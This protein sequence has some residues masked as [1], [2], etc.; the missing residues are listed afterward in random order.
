MMKKFLTLFVALMT[1]TFTFAVY[2]TEPK[3]IYFNAGA[4]S[5]WTSDNAVQRAVLDGNT[6]S[7]IIGVLDYGSVYA[8]TIPAGYHNTIWF[9]RAPSATAPGPYNKTDYIDIAPTYNYVSSFSQNSSTV[10]WE[11]YMHPAITL[12]GDFNNWGDGDRI[13]FNGSKTITFVKTL[14]ADSYEFK[15]VK[16]ENEWRSSGAT[17]AR[18]N[19]GAVYDFSG[20]NSNNTTLIADITGD[21][22]FTYTYAT[23][24]LTVTFPDLPAQSVVFDDLDATILKG[25]EV[26]FAATASGITN[27]QYT[28]YVKPAGGSYG[29]AVSSYTFDTNGE[30]VVKVEAIGDGMSEPVIKEQTVTVYSTYTFTAGTRIYVDFSA[31]TEGAKG[32]NYPS[33]NTNSELDY[34]VNGAGTTKIVLISQNVTWSTLDDFIKTEKNGWAGLKFTAPGEGQNVIIVAADGASYTWGTH[35]TAHVKFFAPRTEL[36]QWSNVYVYAWDGAGDLSSDWPGDAVTTKEGEWYVY[37]MPVGAN[38]IFS[39]NNGMQTN[40]IE[41]IQ[42][43]VCYVPTAINEKVTVAEQCT[44]DYYISGTK[45]L[46]GLGSDW[47][48][49]DANL[50]LDANNQIKFENLAAGTYEFKIT[51]GTWAWS[52]GGGDH[53]DGECATIATTNGIG[54]VEFTIASVQDVTITYHPETERICLGAVTVQTPGNVTLNDINIKVG[55]AKQIKYTKNNTETYGA[56][57][58]ILSGEE[59]IQIYNGFVLG[60]KAGT[61]TVR[62]TIAETAN[63]TAASNEFTVTVSASSEP[64]V[65]PIAPVGGKFLINA[66]G[67]TA[68]FARGNLQYQQ[69]TNTWR[70]APNQYEWK[71]MSNIQM[72]NAEYEGWVDLFCWSLGAENNYGATSNYQKATYFNKEFVDWGT[73]FGDEWSTLS[74]DEL[75]YILNSRPGANNKWGVAMIGDTLGMMLLPD[76]WEAPAGITYV[77]GTNSLPTT[78]L[79]RDEDCIQDLDPDEIEDLGYQ[80]RLKKENLPANKFT[81]EQWAE[82][83]TAGAVFLPFAGRRTG[84]VGNYLDYDEATHPNTQWQLYYENYQGTYWTSTMHNAAKGQPDYYYSFSHY[85]GDDYRWGKGVIWIENGRFGQS[86]RLVKRIPKV[87]YTRDVT[88]GNYGTICLPQAGTIAGATLYSIGSY[89]GS[90]IYV[91]EVGTTL[92]AGVPYIFYATADQL[93]VS[94]TSATVENEAKTANGLHGFYNLSNPAAQFDIPENEGNYILYQN[95]YWLVKDRP[96]YIANYRAYIKINEITNAQ[97]APGIRR[98]AMQVNG[99]NTTTG[100]ESVQQ[101]AVSVQK[102]MIDGELFILRGEKMYDATG[103][104]VK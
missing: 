87:D 28:Y 44:V 2:L 97:Q 80:Y 79:W 40:N 100:V 68:I 59:Y 78:D 42:A 45:E 93:K 24:T 20:N 6:D 104:L 60:V 58:E 48:A 66:H 30:F 95:Q 65:E 33:Q 86:V 9:E 21:Y 10:T 50:K 62:G 83:E 71:G 82:L 91:D 49:A 14:S 61:A 37:T 26:T 16:G 81:L 46:T 69:S 94:Y 84:G 101:S 5:W 55:E 76:V 1:T 53:L 57:Y 32:V 7:P 35:A 102:V 31:M 22:T 51:N 67:D 11:T 47:V 29:S 34:D 38:L 13:S 98:I 96:A 43:D 36:H 17:I 52:I 41:N 39:D 4:V 18:A 23:R 73:L 77:T 103:R 8:F 89:D 54:N 63:Y 92:A 64:A 74:K 70:C 88:A 25:T 85:G 3:V 15:I 75:N 99:Q 19:S 72:G 56:S 27:P 90:M 12:K